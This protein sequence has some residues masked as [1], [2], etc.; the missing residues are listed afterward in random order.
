LLS[1][2]VITK[3]CW[4]NICP[5][6]LKWEPAYE[7]LKQN[8]EIVEFNLDPREAKLGWRFKNSL[9]GGWLRWNESTNIISEIHLYSEVGFSTGAAIGKFGNPDSV[10]FGTRHLNQTIVLFDFTRYHLYTSSIFNVSV[11]F[12][13]IFTSSDEVL[14]NEKSSLNEIVFYNASEGV[15]LNQFCD[16]LTWIDYGYYILPRNACGQ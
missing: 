15:P 7:T 6:R 14:V 2:S 4:E 12:R 9:D 1:D 5:G 3:G 10:I 13:N 16:R 8:P 11:G